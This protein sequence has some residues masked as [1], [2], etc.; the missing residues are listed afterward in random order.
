MHDSSRAGE[1]RRSGDS[2]EQSHISL[3]L[4]SAY[5]VVAGVSIALVSKGVAA[6][7][8]QEMHDMVGLLLMIRI[9]YQHRLLMN[10]RRIPALDDYL[11][12]VNLQLW[13]RFKVQPALSIL[14]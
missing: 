14:V 3:E 13:P 9:N 2:L 5:S 7:G 4:G 6:A 8:A 11:D 1:R 12:R 10:K